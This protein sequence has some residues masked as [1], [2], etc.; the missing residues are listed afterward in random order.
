MARYPTIGYAATR[1]VVQALLDGGPVDFGDH[2]AYVGSDPEPLLDLKSLEE[3]GGAVPDAIDRFEA[4]TEN[5]PDRDALEGRLAIELYAS[6]DAAGASLQVLDDPAFW[7]Y[8]GLKHLWQFVHWREPAV[9]AG[10]G[11]ARI[12]PY[13]DGL[14]ASEC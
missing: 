4:E 5:G 3:F 13:I 1:S 9:E 7:R 14:R 2:V 6:L 10:S 11:W 12:A 8:V